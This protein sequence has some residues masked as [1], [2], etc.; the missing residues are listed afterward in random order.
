MGADLITYI[1]V[2][3]ARPTKRQIESAIKGAD[4]IIKHCKKL[5]KL[6][7]DEIALDHPLL[8]DL[9]GEEG[10]DNID[11]VKPYIETIAL[12]N[13]KKVVKEFLDWWGG[14]TYARDTNGRPDP[15]RPNEIIMVCGEMSWGDLPDGIG[16]QTMRQAYWLGIPY[17]L[18]I[19]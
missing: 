16:Y 19:R 14:R 15:H 8:S 9:I 1:A 10:L 12:S 18:G 4:K 7:D 2:G 3:P 11:L 5:V 17:R 6:S 13:P